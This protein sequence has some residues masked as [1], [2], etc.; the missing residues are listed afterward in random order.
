[1]MVMRSLPEKKAMKSF[2]GLYLMRP[3]GTITGSSGMGVAAAAN[4]ASGAHFL[5]F[6]PAASRPFRRFS[7]TNLPR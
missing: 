5:S 7:L 2:A 6:C 4:M 1:M 3:S